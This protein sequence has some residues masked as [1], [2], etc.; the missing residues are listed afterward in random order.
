ML[1]LFDQIGANNPTSLSNLHPAHSKNSRSKKQC[2]APLTHRSSIAL[3]SP[4]A[5]REPFSGGVGLAC[6]QAAAHMGI[7]QI[8]LMWL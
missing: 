4:L 2:H 7:A 8:S 6:R 5:H 3:A 1:A